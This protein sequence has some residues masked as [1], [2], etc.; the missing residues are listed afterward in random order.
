[1]VKPLNTRVPELLT[2]QPVPVIVIVP[3]DGEKL[4]LEFTVSAPAMLKLLDVVTVAD[5]AIVNP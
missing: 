1:M 5:A 3:E 4:E 2:V